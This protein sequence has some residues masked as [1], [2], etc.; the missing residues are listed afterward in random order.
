MDIPKELNFLQAT[1][2]PRVSSGTSTLE[3]LL[4]Q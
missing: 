2:L 4:H 3:M 1:N